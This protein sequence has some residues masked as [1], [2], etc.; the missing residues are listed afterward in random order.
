MSKFPKLVENKS[1]GI[2]MPEE[3]A[4][5][6][7]GIVATLSK[8]SVFTPRRKSTF[9]MKDT[10]ATER[11]EV[12]VIS[13][14]DVDSQA[15]IV[16]QSGIDWSVYDKNR[17]VLYQH[18]HER[19][20]GKCL[21]YRKEGNRTIAKTSYP[22]KPATYEGDWLPEKIWGL[23]QAGL[24]AGKSVTIL[25]IE[26]NDPS[27]EQREK[28]AEIVW[29]KC[30]VLEYSTCSIP[31]NSE[32]L[33][34]AIEKGFDL[35]LLGIQRTGQTAKRKTQRTERIDRTPDFLRMISSLQIDPQEIANRVVSAL[36]NR[37][38]V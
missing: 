7:D 38:R 23:T 6:V 31:A 37:G 19:P 5:I 14:E 27:P 32:C 28:G 3:P 30:L 36:K 11:T 9:E 16:I 15:D 20:V 17:V 13:T 22:T 26:L 21:W 12:S 18:D 10:D 1:T 34:Q 8:D 4:R 24:L 33:V 25:P 35:D 29:N 2:Y